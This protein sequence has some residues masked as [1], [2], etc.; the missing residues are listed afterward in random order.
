MAVRKF[1]R[2]ETCVICFILVS[3][4]L[5]SYDIQT[6]YAISVDFS[7]VMIMARY[8]SFWDRQIPSIFDAIF[9]LTT[10]LHKSIF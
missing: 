8:L 6:I 7:E 10:R 2:Y 4:D 1:Y 9:A 5:E 3:G